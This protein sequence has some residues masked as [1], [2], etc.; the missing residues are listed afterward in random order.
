MREL[1]FATQESKSLLMERLRWFSE[2]ILLGD[3]AEAP[4]KFALTSEQSLGIG[5]CI[6]IVGAGFAGIVTPENRRAFI[7]HDCTV[8][9]ID[10]VS[11]KVTQSIDLLGPFY[12]FLD[13]Q[14]S[15][16]VIAIHE[17]GLIAFSDDGKI[18]LDAFVPDVV[19]DW[20]VLGNLLSLSLSDSRKM[21]VNLT[22]SSVEF[23]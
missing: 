17:L 12:E 14:P 7:G 10:L 22:T 20:K 11:R 1:Q 6:D 9:A 8:D 2:T 19:E 21:Q 13:W 15:G 18:K 23:L 3:K 16:L 5:V 4:R